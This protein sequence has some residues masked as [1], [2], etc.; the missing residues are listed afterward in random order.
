MNRKIKNV[1]SLFLLLVLITVALPV[2]S[3][4]V[5]A[6]DMNLPPGADEIAYCSGGGSATVDLPVPLPPG[7][8]PTATKISISAQHIEMPNADTIDN[9]LFISLYMTTTS[10]PTLHWEPIAEIRSDAEAA[11]HCMI[12]WRGTYVVFDATL[13]GL[14]P[15]FSTNNI[16]VVPE[17]VV[18]VE[19]HGNSITAT[20]NAPQQIK[21]FGYPTSR[22]FN[23]PTLSLELDKYGGSVHTTSTTVLTGYRGASGYTFESERVGFDANGV[24]T[25][26]YPSWN[27][28]AAAVTEASVTMNGITT[29]YPPP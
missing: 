9:L 2:A 13:Y 3:V 20:L 25:S 29:F 22:I 18:K 23:V 6:K 24:F 12:H 10:K 11:A 27:L 7:Y 21:F 15:S 5:L 14:P 28:N 8:P 4:P 19:R 1:F 16:I 17:G 26:T